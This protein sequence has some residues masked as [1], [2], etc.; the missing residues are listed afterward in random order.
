LDI[1]ANVKASSIYSRMEVNIPLPDSIYNSKIKSLTV[2][3][4]AD[5]SDIEYWEKN[6]LRDI[7]E[8]EKEIY[9]KLDS[10][11]IKSDTIKNEKKSFDYNILVPYIDFNRVSSVSLGLSP[12]FQYKKI[13]LSTNVAYS[14]G[15]KKPVADA[16]LS[17][18]LN[19]FDEY[20]YLRGKIYSN[21]ETVGYDKT[22]PRLLNTAIAALFHKDYY[23]YFKDDGWGFGISY[24]HPYFSVSSDFDNSRPYSLEKTT[25]RSIF[26]KKDWRGNPQIV[27]GN[28]F[29][30]KNS[31]SLIMNKWFSDINDFNL[32]LYLNYLYGTNTYQNNDFE[33]LNLSLYL[34]APTFYTGYDPMKLDIFLQYGKCNN[35]P[36]QYSLKARTSMYF[37]TKF[38][39]FYTMPFGIYEQ[40]S[41]YS[42][43]LKYNFTDIWWRWLGL[44]TYEGRGLDL[45]FNAAAGKFKT[46]LNSDEYYTEA[47]FGFERIP[48][49]FSNLVY[50]GGGV[51]WGIGPI[52]SGNFN[53]YIDLTLPF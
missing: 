52:A 29:L 1:S 7:T 6:S 30:S 36:L 10:L 11:I 48:V 40:D 26:Q 3:P 32:N 20:I 50:F 49:F 47:G 21:I 31:L 35:I 37:I 42:A 12:S 34:S 17:I 5:S 16:L 43:H 14:F 39:N 28:Y 51:V 18:P 9:I 2:A 33:R 23:D 24:H 8:K 13:K 15:L 41:Y 45:V 27:K 44:P 25:N 38:G 22:Y 46:A 53:W 4:M 19:I